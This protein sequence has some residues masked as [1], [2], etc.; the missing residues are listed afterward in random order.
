MV[1]KNITIVL[2]FGIPPYRDFLFKYLDKISS[3]FLIFHN[4]DNFRQWP[5]TYNTKIPRVIQVGKFKIYLNIFS[6]LKDSDVI[7]GSFNFWRPSCWMPLFFL[8]KKKY[9][10]WGHIQGSHENFISKSFKKLCIKKA[11]YILSYTENGK[12]YAV[13]YL[14]AKTDNVFVVRN[15]LSVSNASYSTRNRKYFL[16]VGRIQKRKGLDVFIR[17]IKKLKQE[18][19][20]LKIVG[21]GDYK[22]ELIKLV[23]ELRLQ[24]NVLFYSGTFDENELKT[25]FESAIAY[26]SP[27]QIG[28][29]VVHS[30]AYG[31][32]VLLDKTEK[33]GPEVEYCNNENS[34]FYSGV[35]QLETLIKEILINKE[36]SFKKGDNAY[37]YYKNNLSVDNMKNTFYKAIYE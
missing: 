28:L 14:G 8:K 1:K 15:T 24:N 13:K 3:D 26:V 10:L 16:Y 33:H 32:P 36:E 22:Q 5:Y 18:N 35:N 19:V 6:S 27:Y 29:G 21:D 31:I 30:F 12:N 11:D 2:E 34:Y 7:I 37:T 4:G 23:E 9:I 25:Y 17:Q 20:L